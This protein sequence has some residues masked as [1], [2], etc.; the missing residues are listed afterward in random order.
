MD[1]KAFVDTISKNR[2]NSIKGNIADASISRILNAPVSTLDYWKK[3]VSYK[4]DIYWILKT[5]TNDELKARLEEA[6]RLR[7]IS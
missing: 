6:R 2:D 7:A 5:F 3:G 1:K 4:N